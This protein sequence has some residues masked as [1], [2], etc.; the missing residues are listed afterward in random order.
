[1]SRLESV[2]GRCQRVR[3]QPQDLR[4]VLLFLMAEQTYE[5][6]R[7]RKTG[8][9]GGLGDASPVLA[10]IATKAR[11][12]FPAD[13]FFQFLVG[14]LEFDKGPF[15]CDCRLAR[16]C[17]ERAI[18]LAEG[19]SDPDCAQTAKEAREIAR[20][21]RR[22]RPRPGRRTRV[23]GRFRGGNTER[24]PFGGDEEE[25]LPP[26]GLAD[27][28]IRTCREMG[29]DPEDVLDKIGGLPGPFRIKGGRRR[30]T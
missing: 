15:R 30:K 23:G 4:H 14:K 24:E 13:A 11:Q 18:A 8:N 2:L 28:F 22:L 21:A 5:R 9:A 20:S 1:M 29:V 27:I 12:K 25:G 7:R 19:T 10:A 6:E 16:E 3:W 26:A 17:F